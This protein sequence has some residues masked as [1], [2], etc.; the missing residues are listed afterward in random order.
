[1]S[2]SYP[3][4]LDRL[5]LGSPVKIRAVSGGCIADARIA[6]FRD[7]TEAVVVGQHVS[8]GRQVLLHFQRVVEPQPVEGA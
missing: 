1:M 6:Q 3:A 7:G 5:G 4:I 2:R 8:P